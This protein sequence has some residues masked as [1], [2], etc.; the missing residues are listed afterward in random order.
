MTTR[1][2]HPMPYRASRCYFD[3][4]DVCPDPVHAA[5]NREGYERNFC[6]RHYRGWVERVRLMTRAQ[7]DEQRDLAVTYC[8]FYGFPHDDLMANL[9]G[10]IS[11]LDI[12]TAK[13]GA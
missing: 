1:V 9:R 8:D 12:A 13:I 2:L 4:V 5:I 6:R 3:V 11:V 7:E 10:D